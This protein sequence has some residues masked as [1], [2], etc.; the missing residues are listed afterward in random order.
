MNMF[1]SLL[2]AYAVTFG[3]QNKALFLRNRHPFLDRMLHCTYCTGFH[4]GW[5]TYMTFISPMWY[6]SISD[7]IHLVLGFAMASSAFS[8]GIDTLIRL[9]ETYAPM[10][11]IEEYE[12]EES[13]EHEEDDEEE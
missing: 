8:Y 9:M 11:Q 12:D 4:A 6:E 2:I 1:Y 10:P 13:E 7:T 5:F 3:I